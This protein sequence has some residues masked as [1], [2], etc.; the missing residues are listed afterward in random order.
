MLGIGVG[1]EVWASHWTDT[2][3]LLVGVLLHGTTISLA[4]LVVVLQVE[5]PS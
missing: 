1:L 2:K 5:M 3:R 4:L